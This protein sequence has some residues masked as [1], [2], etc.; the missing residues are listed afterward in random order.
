MN[1][2]DNVVTLLEN[3]EPDDYFEAAENFDI[4]GKILILEP[5]DKYHKIAL[6]QIN[7]GQLIRKYGEIIGK[8]SQTIPKGAWVHVHNSASIKTKD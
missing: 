4:S 5:I 1:K 3:G 7:Q 2:L 6:E 8:A